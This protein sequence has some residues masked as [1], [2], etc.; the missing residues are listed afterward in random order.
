MNEEAFYD[1]E[2]SPKLM[3]LAKAC[4]ARG[5]PFLAVVEYKANEI[6]LTQTY[7]SSAG[8]GFRLALWAAGANGN[9]DSLTMAV[10]RYAA[11]HGH[12][13]VVLELVKGAKP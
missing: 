1:S 4:E 10:Q 11:A 6:A 3:E 9:F 8:I 7:S 12:N 5:L 13:S 2:I